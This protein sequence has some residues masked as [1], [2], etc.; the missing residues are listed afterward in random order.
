[1]VDTNSVLG[2]AAPIV[3]SPGERIQFHLS[4]ASLTEVGVEVVRV[5]CGDP[6]PA[7]PGLRL[8]AMGSAIDG[9]RP[10]HFQPIRPGSF[11]LIPD[12]MPLP[13][14]GSFSFACFLW[15]TW[16]AKGATQT[17][18]ARVGATGEGWRLEMMADAC[19]R[20]V[21]QARD[22][23][24][25][26]VR[27]TKPVL[28]RE[29]VFVAASYDEGGALLLEQ[30]SLDPQAGRDCSC[31]NGASAPGGLAWPAA[32]PLTLAARWT[33]WDG[34]RPVAAA[35]FNGKID[36]PRLYGAALSGD[37]LRALCEAVVPRAGDPLL[38]GAWDL[39]RGI[40]SDLVCDRAAN[41]LDGRLYNLPARGVTGANWDGTV[42][43][44]QAMP[45]QYG[46]VHFHD[47]DMADAGWQPDFALDVPT[48]WP[49]GFYAL[50]LTG[51][52]PDGDPVE[53]FVGFFVRAPLGQAKAPVAFVAS[54]AT[55]LAY[56]N[57]ALRLDQSHAESMLEGLIQLSPDDC[58]IAEHRELGLS[59]YDTHADGSGW[60]YSTALRPILNMRPRA[61]S[62]NYVNDTHVLDWLEEKGFE[63][64]IIADDDIHREGAALL[65]Q[66]RCVITGTH[67]E[68]YSREMWDAFDAYQ[69]GGGRHMYLGGN[70]FYWRISWNPAMPASIEV[71]RDVSGV[72]TWEGEPGEAYHSYTGEFAGLWR[73][74][75][76]A[77]QRLVGVG[78]DA[79]VFDRSAFYR[80]LPASHDPRVAFMFEGIG[81]DERIGDFGLRNGGA[82]GLEID[83]A[84]PTLG[85]PPHLLRVA[86]ADRIGYG[87]L[88]SPEEFRTAHR[89]LDGEQNAN[90][91]ADMIFFPTA[92]GGGVF[93][94]G[95]IAWAC[96][97]SPKGY[98][99]NVSRITENVL[100]RFL[101]PAPFAGF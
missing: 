33:G 10:V 55:F 62:F 34:D 56:A 27:S 91:R 40:G 53:S 54:T 28:E 24:T 87:G 18:A 84:D 30:A 75:G 64:D 44:W 9:R 12:R 73:T 7:G 60:I 71:R 2:Y 23:R 16:P 25:A 49:S 58:Y 93:A 3:A 13:Q 46:A 90:V 77:P 67:P 99:N 59:T 96:A 76:R 66:Y 48:D 74:S 83:R 43:S 79:Q 39:S 63:Y 85:S 88:P 57:S 78:F 97:L 95:S 51:T 15:P 19:L 31:S 35:H 37:Q 65:A 94:T 26:E 86:T 41:R 42:M 17:V 36:R 6:D 4:S 52:R 101:D 8:R 47:D 32:T 89:G 72:R 82:A 38:V 98:A 70:G 80:R 14:L 20:L 5:R 22:G 68:Y 61:N 1:M 92:A 29:W 69:R 100:R 11:A 21:V 50:K 81:A 45:E